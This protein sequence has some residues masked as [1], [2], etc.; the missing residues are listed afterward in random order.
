MLGASEQ[1]LQSIDGLSTSAAWIREFI[2]KQELPKAPIHSMVDVQDVA[3][4]HL[5]AVEHASVA[6]GK[7]YLAAAH[8]LSGSEVA[9]ILRKEFP[10]KRERFP[11]LQGVLGWD[12]AEDW[13]WDTSQ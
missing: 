8:E 3:L 7:R 11:D 2:D 13:K 6:G 4:A 10:D 5:C 12:K 9:H 1:P